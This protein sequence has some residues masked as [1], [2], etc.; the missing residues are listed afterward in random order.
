MK[1]IIISLLSLVLSAGLLVNSLAQGS[2]QVANPAIVKISFTALDKDQRVVSTLAKED[3]RILEDGVPQEII[4]FERQ[5]SVPVSLS[6]LIDVS[7][8]QQ[9]VIPITKAASLLFIGSG[10]HL[11]KDMFSVAIFTGDV[12]I[13]QPLTADLKD[14][15]SAVEQLEFE[16]PP[17][18]G[19]PGTIIP[20][21]TPGGRP[22]PGSTAMWDAISFT[23]ERILARADEHASRTIMLFTDG[24]D[25]TSQRKMSDAINQA[26]KSHVAIYS[27]GI[28][29]QEFGGINQGTLTK[30][31]EQTGGRAFFPKTVGDLQKAFDEI[32]QERHTQY[33]VS[34]TSATKKPN[35][36]VRKVQIEIVNPKKRKAKLK[37]YYQ[38]KY[39]SGG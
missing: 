39:F 29:D 3:I 23:C 18:Y 26:I 30:I 12:L 6:L 31:S 13:K 9:R 38:P 27:I 37:L 1:R 20:K 15:Q 17:G 36:A 2:S 19:G 24:V 14:V 5:T 10:L 35:A 28:G 34:Y 4:G 32:G 21:T 7:A 11:S 22:N 25:T 16:P 33:V 8:S